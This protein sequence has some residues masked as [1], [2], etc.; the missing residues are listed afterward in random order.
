MSESSK[1]PKLHA[2]EL[3]SMERVECHATMD[4]IHFCDQTPSWS[5]L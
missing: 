5:Y 4:G 2:Y 1:S 3:V